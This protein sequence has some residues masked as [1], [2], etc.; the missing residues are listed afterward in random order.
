MEGKPLKE[1]RTQSVEGDLLYA[2]ISYFVL[3]T[4]FCRGKC[5]EGRVKGHHFHFSGNIIDVIK[6]ILKDIIYNDLSSP[7]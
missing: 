7:G 1:E 5:E 3:F 6:S 4:Y 2:F